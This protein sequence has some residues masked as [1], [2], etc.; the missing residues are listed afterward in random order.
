VREKGPSLSFCDCTRRSAN[1]PFVASLR[2]LSREPWR[3]QE[4]PERDILLCGRHSGV[5]L[6]GGFG[7]EYAQGAAG[8]EMALQVESVVDG[9]M[10]REKAL[11]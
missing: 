2:A 4:N 11:G 3:K 5:P 7:S 9:G 8:D 1:R 10:G 6:I